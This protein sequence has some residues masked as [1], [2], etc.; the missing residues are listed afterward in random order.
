LY[1]KT[2]HNK[3]LLFTDLADTPTC[4]SYFI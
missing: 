2:Q 1:N 3:F 4:F